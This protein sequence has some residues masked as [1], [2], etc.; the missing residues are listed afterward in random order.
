L[1]HCAGWLLCRLLLHCCLFLSLR[2]T[3]VLLLSSHCSAPL[4]PNCAGWLLCC[5]WSCRRL[6]LLSRRTLVLLSS[7]HCTALSSSH[8][9]SWLLRCL[10]LHCRLVLS[11]RRNLVL[12]LSSHSTAILSPHHA[13]WLLHCL[14]S[15]HRLVLMLRC[16]LV[17]LSSSHCATLSLSHWSGCLLRSTTRTSLMTLVTPLTMAI[18]LPLLSLLRQSQMELELTKHADC[19]A[20][21]RLKAAMAAYDWCARALVGMKK[22]GGGC[23]VASL[24]KHARATAPAGTTPWPCTTAMTMAAATM[25]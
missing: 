8:R 9:T 24:A 23:N 5:L 11:L 3:L 17:L 19:C 7:S 13:G 14:L 16:P 22:S 12:S 25:G 4:S 2:C 6:I 10:S 18:T 15:R 21:A 1:P 20:T